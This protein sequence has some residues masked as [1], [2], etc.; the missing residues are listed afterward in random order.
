V[1]ERYS[2]AT[3]F[4]MLD[5]LRKNRTD[6]SSQRYF[7]RKHG[8]Y[9]APLGL[10][11]AGE[12]TDGLARALSEEVQKS[13][14]VV[15]QI[16]LR[17]IAY[18]KSSLAKERGYQFSLKGNSPVAVAIIPWI[19]PALSVAATLGLPETD[20]FSRTVGIAAAVV[21]GLTFVPPVYSELI[22]NW[23]K[24]RE[25]VAERGQALEK[26]QATIAEDQARRTPK[27]ILGSLGCALLQFLAGSRLASPP[28][29]PAVIFSNG[30][31]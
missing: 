20:Y 22:R 4:A 23:T 31:R 14:P 17:S 21:S 9:I 27:R 16:L 13:D 29:L 15:G 12:L 1:K 2:L 5:W 18:A 7:E 19:I 8:H 3:I 30:P 25:A 26:L 24:A 10:S 11:L 6:D 28:T